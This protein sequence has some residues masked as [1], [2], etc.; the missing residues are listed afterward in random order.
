M[1]ARPFKR[2]ASPDSREFERGRAR[3]S[4]SLSVV[5][6]PGLRRTVKSSTTAGPRARKGRQRATWRD[7][8][9]LGATLV[10][11]VGPPGQ[12]KRLAELDEL[13]RE[14]GEL[15]RRLAVAEHATLTIAGGQ[16]EAEA[17]LRRTDD[18]LQQ[19]QKMDAIGILAGG[20]A[21][22]FNNLLSIV[23]SY[24][25]LAIDG[26]PESD[27]L[28]AD[29][30]E[31]WTAGE[32][33][34]D[35]TRQLLAFS[36][37]QVLD[38][39]VIDVNAVLEGMR[40]MLRRMVG[41]DVAL[42]LRTARGLGKVLADPVQIEQVVMNLVV[43]AREAMPKGGSLVIETSNLTVDDGGAKDR[44]SVPPGYYVVATVTDTGVGMDS[45]TRARVFEPF[46]TTK[47]DVKRSGLG[48]SMVF[49]IVKQSGGHIEVTSEPGRGSTFK[50]L[51]PRTA[52]TPDATSPSVPPVALDGRGTE[53]ILLVEDDEQVRSL[54]RTILHRNGYTVLEAQNGGEAFLLSEQYASTIHLLLTDVVMPRMSGRQVAERLVGGRQEMRVLYISG[55]TRDEIAHRGVLEPGLAFLQKPITPDSLLRKVR[56]VLGAEQG[57]P[58][59]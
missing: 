6:R 21:H 22:D 58:P 27:P 16:V 55:Y 23:L 43:N 48:L 15:R 10:R 20:I 9:G 28:R 49:G 26:L 35:M 3:P 37:Q 32:R 40:K 41:E 56:E 7:T 51:L 31:V 45:A 30:H 18:R 57:A 2:R 54:V 12:E 53:T 4:D 29:L 47:R 5:P 36:R 34:A 13:R 42:T 33:A 8:P 39:R 17:A 38:P 52:L 19:A 59:G 1:R 25:S 46:F 11:N 50:V 24:T 14:V 44:E